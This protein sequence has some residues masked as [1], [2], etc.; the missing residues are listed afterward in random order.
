MPKERTCIF[1]GG[2]IPP[3]TGL[4]FVRNDGSLLW[5][6]SRKCRV[7]MLRMHRDPRKFKWTIHYGKREIAKPTD[8]HL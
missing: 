3:G 6:C 4:L 1:C 5:F 2:K 8:Q 7:S